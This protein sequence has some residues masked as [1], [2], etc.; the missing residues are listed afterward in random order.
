ML[1]CCLLLVAVTAMNAQTIVT[2]G[3]GTSTSTAGT[4]G[5]PIYRSSST[6]SFH[7]SKSVQLIT[8]SQLSA[9]G[10]ISGSDITSV[11]FY[12]TTTGTPSGSNTWTLNVYLKNSTATSLAS[13]TAWSSMISGATLAYTATMTSA[14]VPNVAGYWA[15]P[16]TG[17]V[18]TGG[19]IEVYIEWFVNGTPVSPFTT[20]A[21]QW[22]YTTVTG[23]QAMGTSNST[24]LPA[25]TSA[26]TTQAR[27]YNV[28]IG[29][30]ATPC[31]GT[32]NPGNTIASANNF[33]CGGN[34]M[35][36]LQN[37]ATGSGITYQWEVSNDAGATWAPISGATS[38]TYSTSVTAT[39]SYRA[40]VTCTNTGGTATSNPVDVNVAGIANPG[41]T[42]SSVVN[43]CS[44]TAFTLSLQNAAVGNGVTYQWYSSPDAVTYAPISGATNSTYSATQSAT[45]SYYATVTCTG[46][47]SQVNSSAITV[48][49]NGPTQCYCLPVTTYGCADG[50]V[51]ARVKLNTLDNNSGTGCPS[52]PNPNDVSTTPNVQGPGYSDYTNNP[53]LTTTLQPATTYNCQVW[54]G[55]Y[56]E[57]YAAWI[58][59]NDDGV[60]DNAT[61][62]IGF[63]NGTVAGSGSVGVL[64][65]SATFPITLSCTPPA[66]THR[67]RVRA[68]YN[69]SGSAVTP[70]GNNSY[71]EVEDY[72]VTITAAPAC[73]PGG[74][75]TASGATYNS[76]NLSWVLSCASA[77]SWDFE[78][79]PAG[80]TQGTGTLVSNVSATTSYTLTGLTD[81]MS[82]DVYYRANCGNGLT[83]AWSFPASFITLTAPCSG[84]PVAAVAAGSVADACPAASF[85][86]TAT[87]AV[88]GNGISHQW[89]RD[90]SGT[91]LP[92][93]GATSASYTYSTGITSP[94]DFRFVST[95]ANS[96]GQ[97]ISN[98]VHVGI[99]TTFY[100][101]Y[102]ASGATNT[103]DEEIYS[104]T[105]NGVN[106]NTFSGQNNGC[107]TAAPG[108][109]SILN[110]YSNFS[111]L[112]AI[113]NLG[114]G[115][116]INF[117]VAED[118]CD[119]A[120]Y[121]AFGT[122][123]WIDY[124]HNGSFDDAGEQVF[125]ESATLTGPRN[126]TGSFMVP[127]TAMS[128]V[129]G[130]RVTVSEGNAGASL[131]PC[132]SYG[133]GETEDY[134]VNLVNCPTPSVSISSSANNVCSGTS[135]TFTATAVDAG[136]DPAYE[137]KINGTAVPGASGST[138]TTS[139]LNN[140]DM[141]EVQI[142][143]DC[144]TAATAVS[145]A[146]TMNITPAATPSVIVNSS[147]NTVCNGGSATLTAV[148]SNGG[149]APMYQWYKNGSI[150]PGE[151]N[152]TYSAS[153]I[154]DGDQY[155]VEMTSNGTCITTPLASSNPVTIGVYPSAGTITTS[156]PTTICSSTAGGSVTLTAGQG[157]SYL[158]SNG[159]TTQSITTSTP[160]TYSVTV[161]TS[162]GCIDQSAP[163]SVTTKAMP[164]VAKIKTVG[165]TS[166]CTPGTVAL[167]LDMA[168]GSTTGFAYQWNLGGSPIPGATDSTFNA[169]A[170]GAGAYT[171][172]I[173][174]GGTCTK[175]SAAKTATVKQTPVA[176]FTVTGATAFCTGGSVTFDAVPVT[177]ATYMWLKNG[178]S[179]AGAGAT[180]SFNTSGDY[181]LVTKLNGCSDTANYTQTV[182]AY[183]A[184]PTPK[185]AVVG[186]TSVCAPNT[187]SMKLDPQVSSN[188]SSFQW[189]LG[190][191]PVS[192]ATDSTYQADATGAYTLTLTT[193][194]GCSKTSSVKNATVKP[195]PVANFTAAGPT[196]FCAG[197]SVTLNAPAITGYTYTWLK[198]GVSAGSG[199]SKAFKVSG[200]Y[201]V[202]ATLAGCRDTSDY[203]EV[204]TV[205]PLPVAAVATTDPTT[206]CAG[207][208]AMLHAT[209]TGAFHTYAWYKSGTLDPAVITQDYTATLAGTY[210]V[211]V[212]DDKSCV[213]KLSSSQVVIKVNPIP[214]ASITPVGS[215]NIAANGSVKLKASPSSGVSW[216]WYLDGSPITGAT[217]KEYIAT[218]GG[219]YTV[220]VTKLGCV[221]VSPAVTVNQSTVKEEE[222]TTS[223]PAGT[224]QASEVFELSA[225]P[226]PVSG[227]LNVNV[228][229][230]EQVDAVLHVMD[231]NGRLISVK[232]MH[233]ASAT[234]DMSSYAQG[235]YLVRYKDA[236]GRTG[237]IKVSKQ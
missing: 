157:V 97:G 217:G 117:N 85:T 74:T 15:W 46:S 191:S 234:I 147:S 93:A 223:N 130:M 102:C 100:Q 143:A 186:S 177:G 7:H 129:T 224:E 199:V 192:G 118:E 230:I 197:G 16:T 131:T 124:N 99:N 159:E 168:A 146:I 218:Q 148:P 65:S 237:T 225:F 66:G 17:F 202:V 139:A 167:A 216:Q 116:T 115:S 215:L 206:I 212:T 187:V 113:T 155:M 144:I 8:A 80:F 75:L 21:F 35:L 59:Y 135:V 219:D 149:S 98:T 156:G 112:G 22:R 228:R 31:A 62:R 27:L 140:G 226:N 170:V 123:I 72:L 101:C 55:Q 23:T 53:A 128:G 210:K 193:G 77:T 107:T 227:I 195:L 200:T 178:T 90:S 201:S 82:Y 34:V 70:C 164:N 141:V 158:W 54:A 25:T 133:Y 189:N 45:T 12:K 122:A 6:S 214:V 127:A 172:T 173:S 204:I 196:E 190:G 125:V 105:I 151:T 163:V 36:S 104:V 188:G 231:M 63:S 39:S 162:N 33:T 152:F 153:G 108:P 43:A 165:A 58:D 69:V 10:V 114:I 208:S 160:N 3:T 41:N 222:G 29:Y 185:I 49:Q 78:Y 2:I 174:G 24:A 142:T 50:D 106:S 56:S 14:N 42:V 103:A 79:G 47:S 207:G 57:G 176:D 109:G 154:M 182:T 235:M 221:G 48:G 126:V 32:P 220:Q 40:V 88:N 145:N 205:N 136:A 92:I 181:T 61:E 198:D 94:T 76:V 26:Y 89:Q 83:S 51:I 138:F 44:G 161:T 111:N 96:G 211:M 81:T 67:L 233:E 229:G 20:A 73:I 179:N 4:N 150:V 60:F 13:G 213:S 166:V 37:P 91:W 64:G 28:Q 52:D 121:Y 120:T 95:C 18:Y 171:V 169:S 175:T 184:A 11:G 68:M 137:W 9:A 232:E 71:G 209:P 38:N 86:L 110:R 30:N 236:S 119:G 132:L 180:K 1:M 87:G 84:S 194:N 19:A 203:S 183:P 5:D 134:L